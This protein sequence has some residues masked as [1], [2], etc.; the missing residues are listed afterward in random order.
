MARFVPTMSR[1]LV[2]SA[3]GL[4]VVV[5][6]G[7]LAVTALLARR[8]LTN[9]KS[10]L[11]IVKSRLLA[12]DE[13]GAH[14]EL[15]TADRDAARADGHTSGIVWRAASA[16]PWLGSPLHTVRGIASTAHDLTSSTLPKV[17][18]VATALSPDRLRVAADQIDV[19]R[20]RSAGPTLGDVAEQ[21]AKATRPAE[22]LP[23]RT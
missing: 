21:T 2:L 12:G 19:Q 17:V 23:K 15:V 5:L 18:T 14:A 9:A 8:E 3:I 4:L 1:R 7:Y 13:A 6:V 22:D 20:L 10:A 16:L 11:S